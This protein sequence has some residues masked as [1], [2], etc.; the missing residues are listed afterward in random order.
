MEM[1]GS[2]RRLVFTNAVILVATL[3]ACESYGNYVFGTNLT[4]ALNTGEIRLLSSKKAQDLIFRAAGTD[5]KP[6]F[7]H[8]PVSCHIDSNEKMLESK[9]SEEE[10]SSTRNGDHDSETR[11]LAFCAYNRSRFS[12]FHDDEEPLFYSESEMASKM[13]AFKNIAVKNNKIYAK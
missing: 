11:G 9:F 4:D 6:D 3:L 8:K 1:Q 5:L 12:S 13:Q 10:S 7:D 2:Y